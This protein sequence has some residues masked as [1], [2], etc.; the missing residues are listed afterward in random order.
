MGSKEK[1]VHVCL[2]KA[3]K[4]VDK[5]RLNTCMCGTLRA[6]VPGACCQLQAGMGLGM[7]PATATAPACCP[8]RCHLCPASTRGG[9][10]RGLCSHTAGGFSSQ[11]TRVIKPLSVFTVGPFFHQLSSPILYFLFFWENSAVFNKKNRLFWYTWVL[12]IDF[13]T[14]LIIQL[15]DRPSVSRTHLG[16][17]SEKET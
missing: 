15:Q 5:A 4:E 10:G 1:R 12:M 9:V 17:A 16:N 7:G 3:E 14:F 2:W 8:Q 11:G 6:W 13:R